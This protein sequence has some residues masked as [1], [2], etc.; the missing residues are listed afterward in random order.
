M[1]RFALSL[2]LLALLSDLYALRCSVG[3]LAALAPGPVGYAL[4]QP[5]RAYSSLTM[6]VQETAHEEAD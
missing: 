3:G 6:Q 4:V 5:Q 2:T 1:T